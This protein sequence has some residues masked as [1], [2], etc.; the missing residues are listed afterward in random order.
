M[1]ATNGTGTLSRRERERL[2]RR[3]AILQAARTVFAEKGYTHA[4]LDE[5]AQLAEFGKGT[6]YNYFPDGKEEILFAILDEVYDGLCRL[7]HETFSPEPSADLAFRHVFHDFVEACFQF[8]FEQQDLF[9]ILIKE[10]HR[11]IFGEEPEKAAYFYRQ[12]ERLVSAL[13]P[14]IERAMARGE[15]KPLSPHAVAHMILG[16]VNGCQIHICMEGRDETCGNPTL[17]APADAADFL[18]TMLL[19]GLSVKEG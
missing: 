3:Q 9:L 19:D 16:N 12:R 6:L 10:A 17:A 4:T 14:T 2:L 8:F 7:I 15:L 11:M 18:T 13:V 5:I 1:I